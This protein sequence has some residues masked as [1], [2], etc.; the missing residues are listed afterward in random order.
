MTKAID[1]PVEEVE[2]TVEEL[3]RL[4]EEF[5]QQDEIMRQQDETMCQQDETMRQQDDALLQLEEAT[6]TQLRQLGV[7]EEKIREYVA[8]TRASNW[9][10]ADKVLG[11]CVPNYDVSAPRSRE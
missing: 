9:E 11:D 3:E 5:R 6:K 1:I 2:V 10:A 7:S 8:H 4:E